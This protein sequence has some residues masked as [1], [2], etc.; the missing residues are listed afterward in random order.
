[1]RCR[2]ETMFSSV[3]GKFIFMTL[4]VRYNK[5]LPPYK[6]LLSP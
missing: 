2:V 4:G 3:R 5:Y 6:L 1:M